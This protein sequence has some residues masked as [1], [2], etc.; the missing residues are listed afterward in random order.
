[1]QGRANR[2]KPSRFVWKLVF[3]VALTAILA[4]T[5]YGLR[6]YAIAKDAVN[7]THVA[8]KETKDSV[9]LADQKPFSVILLGTDTG[10]FGRSDNGRTDSIIIVTINPKKKR[11][12]MISIPRDTLAYIKSDEYTGGNKIN[13]AYAY[14]GVD[15]TLATV[16]ELLNVPINYYAM[17]NMAGLEQLVDAVGGV[18]VNVKFTWQDDAVG[19]WTFTKGPMHLNGVQA[20]GY[21]RMRHKD[22]RDD[23]GRQ[24]RQQE[25]ITQIVHNVLSA[26]SLSHYKDLMKTLSDNMRTDLTF[27]QLTTIAT[28]YGAAAKNIKQE[29]LQGQ[30][31][32]VGDAAYQIPSSKELQRVSDLIRT[33]LGL[34]TEPLNN[35]YNL[36]E[37]AVNAEN[38]YRF[39]WDLEIQH[40][41][42]S[43]YYGPKGTKNDG[44][45]GGDGQ[46]ESSSS[47]T[48]DADT[49]A[50][51]SS[52]TDPNENGE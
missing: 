40:Y 39:D 41:T 17:V 52:D 48:T 34:T 45:D 11:T 44:Y 10:E 22:P 46:A 31:T 9:N 24:E 27:D 29:T 21:A 47:A 14:G 18:D 20:L 51:S 3:V 42:L 36:Y 12:T 49:S 26:K 28:N 8:S 25:V 50:S 2:A 37:N 19:P 1:M 33:E 35:T 32:Y 6:L 5:G 43:K 30:G 38:G 16:K 15:G 7:S 23:Y 13:A 4:V